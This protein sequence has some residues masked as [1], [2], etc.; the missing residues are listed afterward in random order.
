MSFG[1]PTLLSFTFAW[2]I[3]SHYLTFGLCVVLALKWVSLR[4]HI[5]CS[6]FLIQSVTL[7]IFLG[8]YTPL[9]FKVIVDRYVYCHF[10]PCFPV[11]YI[12][13]IVSFCGFMISF[14]F[15][16]VI[17][18]FLV[19]VN[20]LFVFWFVD[21]LVIKYVNP[22]LYLITLDWQSYRLK[23]I[24]IKKESRFSYFLSPHFM[25]LMLFFTFYI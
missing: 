6:Y 11:D 1:T 10:K 5:V 15:R 23:H 18:L 8:K 22:F 24:L 13:S 21:A 9:T 25:I 19:F 12:F 20:L 14:Y 7:C 16:F 17:L 4:Q 2:Y 3:F